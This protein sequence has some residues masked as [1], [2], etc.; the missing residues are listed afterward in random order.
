M[1]SGLFLFLESLV[2]FFL[3]VENALVSYLRESVLP[4]FGWVTT[5]VLLLYLRDL[6]ESKARFTLK[7]ISQGK[8]VNLE[9][10]MLDLR[11]A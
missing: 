5:L 10:S 6:L 8:Q 1:A 4:L 7:Q 9:Q 3:N 2:I 11:C